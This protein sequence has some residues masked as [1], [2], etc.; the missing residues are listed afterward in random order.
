MITDQN[1]EEETWDVGNLIL[2]FQSR[3]YTIFQIYMS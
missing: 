3:D 2:I 1:W